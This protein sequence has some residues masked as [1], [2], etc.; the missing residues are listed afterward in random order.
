MSKL[1]EERCNQID[2]MLRDGQQ[3]HDHWGAGKAFVGK[4]RINY[5]YALHLIITNQVKH[6][7]NSDH[8]IADY[9]WVN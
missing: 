7:G 2:D 8:T 9:V 4:S 6:I 5:A 1:G 3:L